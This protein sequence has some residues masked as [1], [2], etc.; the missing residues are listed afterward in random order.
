MKLSA[1]SDSVPTPFAA[2]VCREYEAPSSLSEKQITT[3]GRVPYTEGV[4]P[5]ERTLLPG[6]DSG[7]LSLLIGVFIL[8][9]VNFR[10]YS[11]FQWCF[12]HVSVKV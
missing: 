4:I 6:Y 12:S 1:L 10:H 2:K 3:L 5:E 9:A 7:V 8:L 11:S